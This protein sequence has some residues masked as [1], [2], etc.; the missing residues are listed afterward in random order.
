M[1]SI[2]LNDK[3]KRLIFNDKFL[4]ATPILLKLIKHQEREI[5]IYKRGKDFRN[6]RVKLLL[7]S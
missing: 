3:L 1:I 4:F 6:Y 2:I 5:H 7:G